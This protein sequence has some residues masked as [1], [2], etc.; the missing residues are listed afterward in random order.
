MDT[1]EGAPGGPERCARSLAAVAIDRAP[2]GTL[3][4][5]R[6]FAHPVRH[7][8]MAGRT[9]PVTLPCL[10]IAPRAPRGDVVSHAGAARLPVGM[11]AHPPARLACVARADAEAG[12]AILRRRPMPHALVGTAPG[13]SCGGRVWRAFFPPRCGTARRPR[14]PSLASPR[15]GRSRA[16]G[17]ADAAATS[18]AVAGT[19]PR[20]G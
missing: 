1:P 14:R 8:G 7:R 11:V 17:L 4:I 9:A 13:W 3:G 5:P 20:R 18:G 2:A 15:S 6:P 19:A 16:G 12:R 10:R